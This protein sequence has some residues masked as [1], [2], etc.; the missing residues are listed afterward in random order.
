[1][2]SMFILGNPLLTIVAPFLAF[3]IS[4]SGHFDI[5][6]KGTLEFFEKV[7]DYLFSKKI[8][9]LELIIFAKKE[10]LDERYIPNVVISTERVIF[11]EKL[12]NNCK[13]L[14]FIYYYSLMLIFVFGIGIWLFNEYLKSYLSYINVLVILYTIFGAL[15]LFMRKHYLRDEYDKEIKV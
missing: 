12:L 8:D 13:R 7:N 11:L 4:V 3:L 5:E 10:S 2:E 6:Y 1:M 14:F 9:N 15:F